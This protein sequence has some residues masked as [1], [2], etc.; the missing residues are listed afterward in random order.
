MTNDDAI[1]ILQAMK[2]HYVFHDIQQSLDMA[3]KALKHVSHEKELETE[4]S[5]LK[6]RIVNWRRDMFPTREQAEKAWNG[7]YTC[8]EYRYFMFHAWKNPDSS[9]GPDCMGTSLFC[10][11]CGK[12]LT[13]EAVDMMM[14]RLEE[15]YGKTE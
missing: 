14:E 5:E 12:P 7:C 4:N 6:R 2:E 9:E 11:A 8:D 3:I 15:I 1:F 10:P 13:N